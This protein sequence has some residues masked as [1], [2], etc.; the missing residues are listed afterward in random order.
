MNYDNPN[1]SIDE[2][3]QDTKKSPGDLRRLDATQTP[4]ENHLLTL[5]QQTQKS[6][7]IIMIIN[8]KHIDTEEN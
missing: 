8:K 5:E 2:I 4:V 7:I 1:D 3:G 6:K